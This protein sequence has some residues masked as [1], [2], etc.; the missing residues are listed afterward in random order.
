M[1][2][3]S[4]AEEVQTRR[5]F[6]SRLSLGLSGLAAAVVSVPIIAYLLSPLLRPAPQVWRD[7]GMVDS[8]RVGDTVEVAIE[9]PSPLPWAGQTALT[10]VWLRR[11]GARE[12]IAFAVN[13]THLGCPV[14]WRAEA[15]LFLCPCHGGVYYADGTVAGGPPPQ[16]LLR[17]DLRIADGDRVEVLTRPLT[18][19]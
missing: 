19:T 6:L 9:E 2:D 1:S 8:F 12:F 11:T 17:Y 15:Q 14:N 16:R 18:F 10:A 5:K 4:V 3:E 13:C 7:V